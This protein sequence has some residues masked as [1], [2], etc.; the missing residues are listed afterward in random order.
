V[1]TYSEGEEDDNLHD[2]EKVDAVVTDFF[3]FDYS[4]QLACG[5]WTVYS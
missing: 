1:W 4:W 5:S 3:S 2:D